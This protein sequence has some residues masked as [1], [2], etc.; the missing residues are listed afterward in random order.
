MATKPAAKKGTAG[1]SAKK[2]TSARAAKKAPT[3]SG[4]DAGLQE[5]PEEHFEL[6]VRVPGDTKDALDEISDFLVDLAHWLSNKEHNIKVDPYV[7]YPLDPK[8]MEKRIAVK[9]A[10]AAGGKPAKKTA[11]KAARKGAAAKTADADRPAGGRKSPLYPM[12]L[13]HN[14]N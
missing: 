13:C 3:V 7:D 6:Y 2:V 8:D 14:K 1:R 10:E 5:E 11:R 12:Y 4:T 9:Q